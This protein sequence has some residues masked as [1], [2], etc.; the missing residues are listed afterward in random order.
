MAMR[1]DKS[2]ANNTAYLLYLPAR[3]LGIIGNSY[4]LPLIIN[5]NYSIFNRIGINRKNVIGSKTFH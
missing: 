5:S 2:R 4:D 1:I 3:G